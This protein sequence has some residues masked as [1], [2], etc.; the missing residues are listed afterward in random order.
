MGEPAIP[1]PAERRETRALALAI[2]ESV[3]ND[4]E[5]PLGLH[6]TPSGMVHRPPVEELVFRLAQEVALLHAQLNTPHTTDFLEAVRIEAAHQRERWGS[7][8]D[9]GKTDADWFW[10]V[11]YLAGKALGASKSEALPRYRHKKRGTTYEVLSIAED[12]NRRGTNVVIYRGEDDGKIWTRPSE[13]FFDGR[14]EELPP[15]P[16]EKKLHH[17]ITTAAAC[18]NWHAHATG[19][20]TRMRPGI[21]PPKDHQ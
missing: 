18:L 16:P 6:T 9:A 11:G 2:V 10:L 15:K 17:I 8:H 4:E 5:M 19:A 7:E 12:E 14:F 21:E 20:D 13:Q 3:R 1:P